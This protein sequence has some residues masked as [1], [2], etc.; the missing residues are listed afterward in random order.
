MEQT[1]FNNKPLRDHRGRFCTKERHYADKALTENKKLRLEC[2]KYQR[3]FLSVSKR[4]TLAERE[5]IELKA[6]IK[7]LE[8][9]Q[10]G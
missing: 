5:I 6:R 7:E 9:M 10:H 8:S 1:L 4:C 3:S 2:E